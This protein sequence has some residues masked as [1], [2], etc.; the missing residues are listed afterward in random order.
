M[1]ILMN[2]IT[3]DISNLFIFEEIPSN[4]NVIFSVKVEREINKLDIVDLPDK[5]IKTPSTNFQVRNFMMVTNDISARVNEVKDS[6]NEPC[7]LIKLQVN[8]DLLSIEGNLVIIDNQ[9]SPE[10]W[11]YVTEGTKLIKLVFK[12]HLPITLSVTDY[13]LEELKE[14]STYVLRIE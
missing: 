5:N 14:K 9:E 4:K 7:A 13:G 12:K 11:V 2:T 1:K 10:K 3:F 6:N 8:D